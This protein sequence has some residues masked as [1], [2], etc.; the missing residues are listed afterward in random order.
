MR[1][2]RKLYTGRAIRAD[3]W[4]AISIAG[5][6]GAHTQARRLDKAESSARDMLSLLLDKAPDSFDVEIVP[7]L[8]DPERLA[9]EGI[10]EA[11]ANYELA[12]VQITRRQRE[13]AA[14]LVKGEG[15]TI[16]DAGAIMGISYQR[17]AQLTAATKEQ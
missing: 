10:D 4:W 12:K 1:T 11:K 5:F 7:D 14:L 2:P 15:L 17:I 16:R 6:P 8:T 13:A 3:G 9:L